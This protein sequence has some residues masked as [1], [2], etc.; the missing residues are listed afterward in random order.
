MSAFDALLTFEGGLTSAGHVSCCLLPHAHQLS[1]DAEQAIAQISKLPDSRMF[2]GTMKKGGHVSWLPDQLSQLWLR[3]SD[4]AAVESQVIWFAFKGP[5]PGN[6]QECQLRLKTHANVEFENY[7]PIY[8][9]QS[10]E[11]CGLLLQAIVD[12]YGKIQPCSENPNHLKKIA[13]GVKTVTSDP[14]VRMFANLAVKAGKY[15]LPSLL[16]MI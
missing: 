11:N 8:A 5:A 9:A 10:G 13:D 4:D 2:S 14:T 15:I 16:A 3:E 1:H 6:L 12:T 7:S